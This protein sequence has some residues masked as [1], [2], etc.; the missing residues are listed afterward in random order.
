MYLLLFILQG[1]QMGFVRAII[2]T[3][4]LKKMELVNESVNFSQL[5]MF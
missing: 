2:S 3:N 4:A 5:S 1:R